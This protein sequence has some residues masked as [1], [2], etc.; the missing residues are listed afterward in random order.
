MSQWNDDIFAPPGVPRATKALLI[1]TIGAF[2]VQVVVEVS[3]RSGAYKGIVVDVFGLSGTFVSRLFLWQAATYMFLHDTRDIMHVLFNML[4]LF[5]FGPATERALGTRR[6]VR[7]YFIAGAIAGLGWLAL[8]GLSSASDPLIGAS[9]AVLGVVAAFA[10][11]DPDRMLTLLVVVFPV[12]MKARTLALGY[13]A[14]SLFFMVTGTGGTVAHAAHLFGLIAGYVIT[15][16]A[17]RRGIA[18][19]APGFR[20]WIDE[21][22]A[23]FRRRRMHLVRPEPASREDVPPPQAEVDRILDKISAQ[24]MSSVTRDELATLHRASRQ[25][26]ASGN[27]S[28]HR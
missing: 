27:D 22:R 24:G 7:L 20:A 9:G 11:L 16:R 28:R 18:V 2:L 25:A 21:R 23:A 6:F 1:A 15:R 8:S 3:L 14:F 13:T 19:D 26:P 4:G 17:L 5:S 12:T 10:T